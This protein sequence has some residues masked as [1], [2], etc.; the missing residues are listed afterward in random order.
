MELF[1]RLVVEV[2][3]CGACVARSKTGMHRLNNSPRFSCYCRGRALTIPV[4]RRLFTGTLR[5]E[6]PLR[7]LFLRIR[8][9]RYDGSAEFFGPQH[10]RQRRVLVHD[11]STEALRHPIDWASMA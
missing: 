8:F 6:E 10:A 11:P 4:G 7:R 2:D 5:L 3:A 9:D 1:K